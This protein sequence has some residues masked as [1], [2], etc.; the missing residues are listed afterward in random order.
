MI[1]D[2]NFPFGNYDDG[3]PPPRRE[4][5]RLFPALL[6]LAVIGG[7]AWGGWYFYHLGKGG[8][9]PSE[10]PVVRADP[11]PYRQKPENPGGMKIPYMDKEIYQK[12][13]KPEKSG[14]TETLME[15]PEEPMEESILPIDGGEPRNQLPPPLANPLAVSPP[16]PP[17]A[18]EFVKT[19]G[20]AG[21]KAPAVKKK[22]TKE[23]EE[24][25]KPKKIK[26][27]EALAKK[28]E[29]TAKDVWVQLGTYQS[30]KDATIAWENVTEKSA[31]AIAG[32]QVKIYS[33]DLADKG[34]FYSLRAG[35][36]K[37]DKEAKE[38]CKK[39]SAKKQS[40]VTIRDKNG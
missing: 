29:R 36:L 9:S 2:E 23:K 14:K 6:K 5:S 34:L 18:P 8:V 3:N 35:P 11:E 1:Y 28:E 40:C 21:E 4:S 24:A 27:S 30:E 22:E 15:P 13:G 19:K 12:L 10:V 31:G 38:L 33:F 20:I 39:L 7:V 32:Y 37:S 17:P 25:I 16:P 26:V